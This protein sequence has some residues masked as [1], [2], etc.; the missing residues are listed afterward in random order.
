M[1]FFQAI[2]EFNTTVAT[3]HHEAE[4]LLQS[5]AMEFNG[6]PL[7]LAPCLES[8]LRDEM[9]QQWMLEGQQVVTLK[10]GFEGGSV[11][12]YCRTLFYCTFILID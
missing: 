10:N 7:S 11:N 3:I 6:L 8:L 4:L 2:T 9:P 12:S 1:L 5:A